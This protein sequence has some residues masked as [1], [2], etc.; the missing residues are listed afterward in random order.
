MY[1]TRARVRR[2]DAGAPSR[3][4]APEVGPHSD[5]SSLTRVVLPARFGPSRANTDPASTVSETPRTAGTPARPS[6]PVLY[7]LATFSNT[8]A[9]VTVNSR[10]NVAECLHAVSSGSLAHAR[11]Q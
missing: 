10:A 8:A 6:G 2:S 5:S 7:V 3:V 9:A 11:R 4:I 1:P